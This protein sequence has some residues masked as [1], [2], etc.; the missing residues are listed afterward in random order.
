MKQHNLEMDKISNIL[1]LC[2]ISTRMTAKTLFPEHFYT[3]FAK[4]V[5]EKIFDLINGP[6]NKV[7]IAVSRGWVSRLKVIG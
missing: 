4:N 3:P 5:H 1:S 6:T 7:A 2:A